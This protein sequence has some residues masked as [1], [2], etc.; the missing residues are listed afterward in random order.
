MSVSGVHI[1]RPYLSKGRDC[2]KVRLSKQ[3]EIGTR[4]RDIQFYST[5]RQ[6][7]IWKDVRQIRFD[8]FSISLRGKRDQ[9]YKYMF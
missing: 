4:Y 5:Q 8:I 2:Y 9:Q 3:Q 7:G 6:P 1:I